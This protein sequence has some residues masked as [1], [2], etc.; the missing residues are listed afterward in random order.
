M[1]KLTNPEPFG[2]FRA[3][4]FGWEDCG[5]AD[6]GATP[7]YDQDAIDALVDQRDELLAALNQIHDLRPLGVNST[8]YSLTVEFLARKA[9][10]SAKGK[11]CQT[12]K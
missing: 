6:E 12:T 3:H 4:P 10:T 9:I 5:E 2:F 7:L 11:K 1:S 8:E